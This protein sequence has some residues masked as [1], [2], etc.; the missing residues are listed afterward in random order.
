MPKTPRAKMSKKV[1][2]FIPDIPNGREEIAEI[3][4]RE[5]CRRETPY[6]GKEDEVTK[7]QRMLSFNFHHHV[8]NPETVVQLVLQL[9]KKNGDNL[10]ESTQGQYIS[11]W[12]T[13]MLRCGSQ[14]LGMTDEELAKIV[15]AL[16]NIHHEKRAPS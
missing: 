4:N 6:T 5:G 11:S 15:K 10:A 16:D 7:I 8:K 12:K 3:L 13:F 14:T 2:S 1:V 9:K